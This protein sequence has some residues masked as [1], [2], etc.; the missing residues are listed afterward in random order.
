[1]ALGLCQWAVT[2]G[3]GFQGCRGRRGP[4]SQPRPSGP[5]RALWTSWS[6]ESE[7]AFV[8]LPDETMT[9]GPAR[10]W[11][12]RAGSARQ[13]FLIAGSQGRG[14]QGP[15]LC[16]YSGLGWGLLRTKRSAWVGWRGNGDE[17]VRGP[18]VEAAICFQLMTQACS[19]V[20]LFL[21]KQNKQKKQLNKKSFFFFILK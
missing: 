6:W 3:P 17:L 16:T 12:H 8:T 20:A 1:M 5:Q 7:G 11:G 4:W 9:N 19:G 13:M 14:A 2:Q 21:K 10:P 15:R 18:S